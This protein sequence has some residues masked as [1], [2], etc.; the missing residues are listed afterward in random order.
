[1]NFKKSIKIELSQYPIVKDEKY[2]AAFKRN[3][4]VTTA[5]HSC[6]EILDAHYMPGNDEDS[7]EL[8]QQKQCFMYSFFTRSF[9]VIWVKS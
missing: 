7:Q 5:T 2:F 6:E 1:M 9:N 4:L 8:F 3:L